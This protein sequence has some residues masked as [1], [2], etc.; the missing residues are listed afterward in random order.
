VYITYNPE[1]LSYYHWAISPWFNRL[2]GDGKTVLSGS[3]SIKAF[4]GVVIL[5]GWF[6]FL[7]STRQKIGM[8]GILLTLAFFA[9]L[10]WVLVDYGLF[11]ALS[12]RLRE[13]L[14]LLIISFILM[15]GALLPEPREK[16]IPP[17]K[18]E[19]APASPTA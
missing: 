8:M 19:N 6:I 7:R 5:G 11:P 17:P 1:G 2:F 16:P 3:N 18:K 14:F 10:G 13:H 4:L 12:T 9:T 15:L